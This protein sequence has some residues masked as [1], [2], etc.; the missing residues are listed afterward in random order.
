M[1]KPVYRVQCSG[2][3][4]RWLSIPKSYQPG[5]DIPHAALEPQPTAARAGMWPDESAALYAAFGAGWS[6][7]TCPDCRVGVPVRQAQKDE[8]VVAVHAAPN[9]SPA[10]AEALGALVDVAKQQA[11]CDFGH[12]HPEHPCGRAT[13]EA[14]P[15]PAPGIDRATVDRALESLRAGNHITARLLLE[16]AINHGEAHQ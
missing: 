2:P 12:P 3:C 9:P 8:P 6:S 13:S 10:A 4:R 16:S 7:G 5:E 1:I 11:A 15:D 14:Q